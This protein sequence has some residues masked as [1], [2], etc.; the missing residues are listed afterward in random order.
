[1][2]DVDKILKEMQ[3]QIHTYKQINNGETPT[4]VV[5]GKFYEDLFCESIDLRN[6]TVRHDDKYTILGCKYKVFYSLA[7]NEFIV[8]KGFRVKE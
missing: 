4:L 1:M 7:F 8:G 2:N 3:I 6:V 5:S